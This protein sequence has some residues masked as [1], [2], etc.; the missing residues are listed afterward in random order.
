MA[1]PDY[2]DEDYFVPLEDQR[3]FGAGIK[4][5][6]VPF[7]RAA[8]D[9]HTTA[10]SAPTSNTPTRSVADIY[11]SI[12]LSKKRKKE[13]NNADNQGTEVIADLKDEPSPAPAAP[14]RNR[15]RRRCARLRPGSPALTRSRQHP[16]PPNT[17]LTK[18]Q[19]STKSASNTPT[20]H[21]I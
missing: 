4:R 7:V 17:Y 18:P 14:S 8:G 1:Q 19:W 12:V 6:R 3:V 16:Q 9:L 5:K 20:L 13:I 11:S 2:D 10:P 15:F 21:R